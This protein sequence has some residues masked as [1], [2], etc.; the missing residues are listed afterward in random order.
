MLILVI[1]KGSFGPTRAAGP[2]LDQYR[3]CD[4]E[5]NS[6]HASTICKSV[7]VMLGEQGTESYGTI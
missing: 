3:P 4:N 6:T 7:C 2:V 5:F 1:H